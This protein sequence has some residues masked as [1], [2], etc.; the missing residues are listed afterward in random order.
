MSFMGG[1]SQEAV[2]R[3]NSE[4]SVWEWSVVNEQNT[5]GKSNCRIMGI[6]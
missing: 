4:G 1:R 3:E 2:K 5:V 6:F